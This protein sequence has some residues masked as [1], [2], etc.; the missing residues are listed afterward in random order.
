MK[1][2]ACK[3]TCAAAMLVKQMGAGLQR[4]DH[5]GHSQVYYTLIRGIVE[6]DLDPSDHPPLLTGQEIVQ[7]TRT[8]PERRS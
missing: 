8:W 7:G 3:A 4:D 1:N 2:S 6:R 5:G